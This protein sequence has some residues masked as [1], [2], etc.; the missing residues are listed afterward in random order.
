MKLKIKND[1]PFEYYAAD[2]FSA[3]VFVARLPHGCWLFLL[4][5]YIFH[6]ISITQ[7]AR[8]DQQKSFTL[9]PSVQVKVHGERKKISNAAEVGSLLL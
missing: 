4:I 6:I 3:S 1:I 8:A 9:I 7:A 5:S 2:S